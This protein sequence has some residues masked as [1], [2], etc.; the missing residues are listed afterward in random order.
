MRVA[1]D[2]G[3]ARPGSGAACGAGG[4]SPARRR[5]PSRSARRPPRRPARPGAGPARRPRRRCRGWRGRA[6]RA[7]AAARAPR[8]RRGR[9][10]G[11]S[12]R[13]RA[14]APRTRPGN[15]RPPR[16]MCVSL[17]MARRTVASGPPSR[18]AA[19]KSARGGIRT[20]DFCLRR[21]ALYP[22]SYS[23]GSGHRSRRARAGYG[24]GMRGTAHGVVVH[25][26]TAIAALALTV[27][28]V[29]GYVQRAFVDSDQFA[30]RASAA[31]RDDRVRAA[32]A[33]RVT[34]DLVLAQQADLVAARP[35]IE[36]AVSGV[37][38]GGAFAGCSAP[39]CATCTA[40]RSR[41]RDTHAHARRR[42]HRASPP[43]SS[44]CGPSS[45]SRSRTGAVTLLSATSV[46][47]A[48]VPCAARR[49]RALDR[50]A[51][52]ARAVAAARRR[53]SL[54]RDRR[55]DG[56]PARAGAAVGGV[57]IVAV[58]R[59]RRRAVGAAARPRSA[60]ALA[61]RLGRLPRRPAHARLAARR[62][63]RHRRRGA[64]RRCCARSTSAMP[65]RRGAGVARRAGAPAVA[66]RA[67]R[68]A[69]RRRRAA[70]RPRRRARPG[71]HARSAR[72]WSTRA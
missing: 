24:R 33:T 42:R 71:R 66:R 2:D 31:L 39:P 52:R 70:R 35:L 14:S 13:R 37:V 57:L 49:R 29:A 45:A 47:P 50:A 23:R 5:G 12:R 21:A 41:D 27:A 36:S 46:R 69:A 30:N 32:I 55:R 56:G 51:R 53:S 43:R 1:E 54:S 62:L 11:G 68:G 63:R 17:M 72:S 16:G 10:R 25:V 34:D 67:R 28:V 26:L 60:D 20:P 22:L 38:G 9:R 8:P 40:R 59:R 64:R 61:R 15:A 19:G 58:A 65:L 48:S 3:V 4:R 18:S 44:R 6:G 7:T